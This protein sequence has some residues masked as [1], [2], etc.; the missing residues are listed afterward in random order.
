MIIYS[1]SAIS[2][3]TLPRDPEQ[4]QNASNR[5]PPHATT[6]FCFDAEVSRRKQRQC[7]RRLEFIFGNDVKFF[8]SQ[9]PILGQA[10]ASSRSNRVVLSVVQRMFDEIAWYDRKTLLD[11]SRDSKVVFATAIFASQ[12]VRGDDW[13]GVVVRALFGIRPLGQEVWDGESKFAKIRS[14]SSAKAG[15]R[16]VPAG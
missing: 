14:C 11:D 15:S 2:P 7:Q 5:S 10:P 1:P 9:V 6:A 12:Q 3:L 13:Q 8:P 4:V 16:W